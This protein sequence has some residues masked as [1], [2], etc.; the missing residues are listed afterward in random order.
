MKKGNITETVNEND[1]P[2]ALKKDLKQVSPKIY[3]M[4]SL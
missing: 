2:S 4:I 3:F 1:K